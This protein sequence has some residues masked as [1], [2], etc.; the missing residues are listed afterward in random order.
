MQSRYNRLKVLTRRGNGMQS[1]IQQGERNNME[2]TQDEIMAQQVESNDKKR[3]WDVVTCTKG[4]NNNK[5]GIE[6]AITGA[7]R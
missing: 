2:W 3:K 5:K 4:E 7:A 6:D 1:W